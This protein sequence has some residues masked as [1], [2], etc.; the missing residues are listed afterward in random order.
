MRRGVSA[1][2]SVMAVL[3]LAASPAGADGG[4]SGAHSN[5]VQ[6][7]NSDPGVPVVRTASAVA[8]NEGGNVTDTNL[9]FARS[10][11]CTGCRTVA[12]AVQVVVVDGTPSN[13]Q[14]QNAAIAVNDNCQSCQ[15]LA[16]AHQYVIQTSDETNFGEIVGSSQLWNIQSQISQVA[17]SGEDF[18]TMS[19]QLDQLSS[20][21]YHAVVQAVQNQSNGDGGHQAGEDRQLQEQD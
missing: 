17:N 10:F 4:V 18:V 12:V 2:V 16:Y 3:L 21:F 14:P 1:F 15:T 9:A 19:S 7:S 11:S 5:I 6:V 8:N 20:E 13:Y